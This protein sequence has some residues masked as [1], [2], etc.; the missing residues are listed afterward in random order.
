MDI[1]V[2]NTLVCHTMGLITRRQFCDTMQMIVDREIP[3][4]EEPSGKIEMPSSDMTD[5][6]TE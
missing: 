3:H 2:S 6:V 4:N 1:D 5:W